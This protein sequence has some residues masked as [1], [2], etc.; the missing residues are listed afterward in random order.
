MIEGQKVWRAHVGT[1][2]GNMASVDPVWL[3]KKTPSAWTYS[4]KPGGVTFRCNDNNKDRQL[5]DTQDEAYAWLIKTLVRRVK[6]AE[7]VLEHR[8]GVLEKFERA[9]AQAKG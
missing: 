5:F 6:S 8:K 2:C 1:E 9:R 7:D 4:T 3:V